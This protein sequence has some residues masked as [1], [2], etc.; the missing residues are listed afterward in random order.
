MEDQYK[1]IISNKNIYQEFELDK[2]AERIRVGTGYDCDKRLHREQF[3]EPVELTFVKNG[4]DW[5]VYCG[6]NLYLAGKDVRKLLTW[7]LVHGDELTVRYKNSDQALFTLSYMLDF[8]QEDMDYDCMI[9]VRNRSA[10]KIGGAS[11]CD[12]FLKSVYARGEYI[13]LT[14]DGSGYEITGLRSAVGCMINGKRAG[15]KSRI[16]PTDFLSVADYSFYFQ[17]DVIYTSQTAQL[18]LSGLTAQVS[19]LCSPVS[20]YPRFIRNARVK[21]RINEEKIEILDPPAQI[22][23]PKSNIV[24]KILPSLAMLALIVVVRGF[25]SSTSNI[26]FII[27]SAASMTVGILTSVFSVISERKEYARETKERTEKYE[28]YIEGKREQLAQARAEECSAL[29]EIYMDINNELGF[30]HNFSGMLFDREMGDEDFL[31]VRLGTGSVPA[32]RLAAY[33]KQERF[34]T[35]DVLAGLPA[36]VSHDFYY[37][38]QA[39]VTVDLKKDALMGIIGSRR[40]IY[41]FIKNMALDLAVRHYYKDLEMIFLIKKEELD[42]Y[43]WIRWLPHVLHSGPGCRGI[44]CDELSRNT[45]FEYLYMELGQRNPKSMEGKPH[46]VIFVLEDWGIKTHPVSQYIQSSDKINVSFVFAGTHKEE[47]PQGCKKLVVLDPSASG[48]LVDCTDGHHIQTFYYQPVTDLMASD[49]ALKLAP[50]Y[51]DEVN[52]EN[53][54]T[55]NISLFAMLNIL[56]AEDLDLESRWKTSQIHKSMAAPLGVKTKDQIVYLDLHEKAHGPHGLVA[57]TTGSGKSEILQTYILSMATLYHPYEVGF[58]IIDFKGGGMA[59][60]FRD[61][62]HLMGAITNIDGREIS[63]SL[64]SI[65]AELQKRQRLFAKYE[66]N[67]INNYIKLYKSGEISEPLP[68]LIIVVDEFAELKAEQPDFMK[69]LISAARIGRSL[70][71]HLI[72]ATQKPAGQVNE[73]IWS[74]SRFKLCLKV[75]TREDSNEVLKSPLAAEIKEPGRTYLQVGNNEIFLLFQSAYSGA[76]A[77]F[78]ESARE[79]EFSIYET[80]LGESKKLVYKNKRKTSGQVSQ[81][82]LDAIVEYVHRFCEEKHIQK[83][84]NICLPPLPERIAFENPGLKMEG[85]GFVFP[86]GIYDDPS[87]QYQGAAQVNISSENIFVVGAAQMGKT[88]FLQILLR[89]IGENFSPEQI[90]VYIMDFGSMTLK[91]FENMNHVGGVVLAGEDEKLKNLFKLLKGEMLRRREKLQ[92]AGVSSFSAYLEAGYEDLPQILVLMDNFTAFKELY[93]EAFEGDLIYLCREGITQGITFV[94]TNGGTSGFGYKYLSNFACRLALTCN[95]TGEYASVFDRCR[96]QP[97]A[98]PGRMLYSKDKEIYEMQT[99]M[100]FEG[101]KEI[102]RSN[103]IREFVAMVNGRYPGIYAKAVPSIPEQLTWEILERD[104]ELPNARYVYPLALD[105]SEVDLTALDLGNLPEFS[106]IGNRSQDNGSALKAILSAVHS[107]IFT[108]PVRMYF[109]DSLERPFKA[110]KDISYVEKYTIDYSEMTGILSQIMPELERRHD[111]LMEG[112]LEAIESCPLILVVVNSGDGVEYLSSSKELMGAYNK[113]MK[114]YK[115]LRITFIFSN[116][117]DGAVAYGA[118]ELLKKLKESRRALITTRN[119]KEF[120]FC[121]I[122]SNAVRGMKAL[123]MDDAYLLNGSN[124]DRIK[125]VKEE[126]GPWQTE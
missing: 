60:Q 61:L 91:N 56:S 24:L 26:S 118:P 123:G 83:L 6:E 30:V 120:K 76:P 33:K 68:H 7:K 102:D 46:L 4:A 19:G 9:D 97:R 63:R 77:Y 114:Q 38:D 93:S 113:I 66:V 5:N 54:L 18:S 31:H 16:R 116:V 21:T 40:D 88:N 28:R 111:L 78:D 98:L 58:V 108:D 43:E 50:I 15:L 14:R 36:Q 59:N 110:M 35:D 37:V 115:S 49:A 112:G 94:V 89:M 42:Q 25:M 95:D 84:P 10:I 3:F 80:N 39:P 117:A 100:A 67:N 121:D 105:Y 87:S 55:K 52:L 103:A 23:K 29:E 1:I 104:Y 96:M 106:I 69:E 34:E 32:R 107:K 8:E 65:K 119:L 74:N 11:Q 47:M 99:Y 70:G 48:Q 2:D 86:V 64:L 85:A 13:E 101:D 27:F 79:Q 41:G 20:K 57:G 22:Q 125:L 82:Q 51:C 45:I 109:L 73:Q 92:K 17:Q 62:P 44:V 122:P 81:T 12:I 53:S 71:V 72:L 75:Q 124:V 126:N 90:S